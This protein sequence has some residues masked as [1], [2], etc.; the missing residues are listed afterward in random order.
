LLAYMLA[1]KLQTN[2]GKRCCSMLSRI[3]RMSRS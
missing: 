1:M 3:E 2:S